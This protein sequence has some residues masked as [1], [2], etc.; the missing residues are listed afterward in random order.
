MKITIII[1][2][3]YRTID[4]IYLHKTTDQKMGKNNKRE[5]R[6]EQFSKNVNIVN[7]QTKNP[8]PFGNNFPE[9]L[10]IYSYILT[11]KRF[12]LGKK[13]SKLMKNNIIVIKKNNSSKQHQSRTRKRDHFL[14]S[15]LF[16]FFYRKFYIVFF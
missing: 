15:Y 13:S 7:K 3:T 11:Y 9:F 8:N 12:L 4:H 1:I 14:L 5:I 2:W 6:R 16:F 10:L